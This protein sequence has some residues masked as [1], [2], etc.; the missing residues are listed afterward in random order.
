MS[1]CP[2]AGTGRA[3]SGHSLG[4]TL[5][6]WHCPSPRSV[7]PILRGAGQGGVPSRG[8]P[9]AAAVGHHVPEG[10]AVP[11]PSAVSAMGDGRGGST[12]DTW[13]QD[14]AGSGRDRSHLS[15]DTVTRILQE[16]TWHG[17]NL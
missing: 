3:G 14:R 10:E 9:R 5:A 12:G 17:K 7:L 11:V 1:P 15:S 2:C 16:Q 13:G 4:C 6:P 8:Q